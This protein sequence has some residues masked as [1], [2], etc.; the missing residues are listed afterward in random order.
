[1]I[2]VNTVFWCTR[3]KRPAG[4]GNSDALP[5]RMSAPESRSAASPRRVRDGP[6][7]LRSGRCRQ[8]RPVGRPSSPFPGGG[9]LRHSPRRGSFSRP[10]ES[11]PPPPGGAGNAGCSVDGQRDWLDESG[12]RSLPVWFV[13]GVRTRCEFD[14]PHP[15]NTTSVRW[16][17]GQA[18]W[19]QA[20]HVGPV[21]DGLVIAESSTTPAQVPASDASQR[22]RPRSKPDPSD[23]ASVASSPETRKTLDISVSAET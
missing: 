18:P 15:F 22:P 20:A 1:M 17:P 13:P 8:G 5:T 23:S 4:H 7:G 12:N 21:R 10:E 6:P 19:R 2:D 16:L 11:S 14:L 3:S 9:R